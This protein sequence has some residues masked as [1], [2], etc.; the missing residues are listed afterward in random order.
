MNQFIDVEK[1]LWNLDV[2]ARQRVYSDLRRSLGLSETEPMVPLPREELE[3][4]LIASRRCSRR[5][6]CSTRRPGPSRIPR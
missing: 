4:W 3:A 5:R 2:A 6:C 1:G